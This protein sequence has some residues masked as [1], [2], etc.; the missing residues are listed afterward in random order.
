[1]SATERVTNAMK[2]S[3]MLPGL[4][5]EHQMAKK[6]DSGDIINPNP[7]MTTPERRNEPKCA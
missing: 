1:M 6:A 4:S 5:G 7:F 2:D 3:P